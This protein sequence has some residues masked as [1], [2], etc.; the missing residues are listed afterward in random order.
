MSK[1]LYDGPTFRLEVAAC[2]KMNMRCLLSVVDPP[3]CWARVFRIVDPWRMTRDILVLIST[4][5]MN[6]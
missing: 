4:R 3:A 1:A 5:I 2:Q 6:E